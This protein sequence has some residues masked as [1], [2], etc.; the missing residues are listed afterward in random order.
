MGALVPHSFTD[1]HGPHL[2]A[3]LHPEG[4]S[5]PPGPLGPDLTWGLAADTDSAWE[6]ALGTQRARLE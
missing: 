3:R 6:P 5:I 1:T 2:Q 4:L